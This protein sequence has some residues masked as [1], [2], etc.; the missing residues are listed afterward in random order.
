MQEGV[1]R[2]LDVLDGVGRGGTE[3]HVEAT[4][5]EIV[6]HG[7]VEGAPRFQKR[8]LFEDVLQIITEFLLFVQIFEGFRDGLGGKRG[9]SGRNEIF[10]N[11]FENA[12]QIGLLFRK[13]VKILR[14]GGHDVHDMDDA[15]GLQ[16][17][18]RLFF[19]VVQTDN[20]DF[21]HDFY[22]R[23]L[24]NHPWVF[25]HGYDPATA[26]RFDW[27]YLHSRGLRFASPT[28]GSQSPLWGF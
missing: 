19:R 8:L 2:Q 27:N 11:G 20:G 13:R 3:L 10:R 7:G 18:G 6:Q 5:A 28:A 17:L 12:F 14:G 16:G 25:T 21:F 9:L 24:L 26:T 1:F 22:H 15:E 4:V 23:K